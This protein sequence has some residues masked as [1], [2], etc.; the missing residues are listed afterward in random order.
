M[1]DPET[2]FQNTTRSNLPYTY[3]P[4]LIPIGTPIH[5]LYTSK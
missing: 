5:C 3:G 2:Y 4:G 1:Y